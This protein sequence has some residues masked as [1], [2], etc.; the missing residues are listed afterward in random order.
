LLVKNARRMATRIH[1]PLILTL[2]MLAIL[3]ATLVVGGW[4]MRTIV[5]DS[6]RNAEAIRTARIYAASVLGAQLDEETGIRGYA[7]IRQRILI[8]PYYVGRAAFPS[9]VVRLR[10][11]LEARHLRQALIALD[12]AVYVNRRWNQHVAAPL[13]ARR[14]GGTYLELHG[15]WL[16]D[17]FRIDIARID[18]A[19]ANEEALTDQR[20]ETA[21]LS[22]GIFAAA[23]V[24]VVVLAALL[25]SVQQYQLSLR[26]ERQRAQ[27]EHQRRKA[28]ETRTALETERRIADTL[29]EAFSQRI[30]PTLPTVSFSAAYVPAT[31]DAKV[32]GDWYDVLQ[33]SEDRVLIAIGDVTGHGIEAVIAMNKARQLL[34]AGALLD[35]DPRRV[36]ERVNEVL[37]RDE[38]SPIT[39]I[40]GVINTRTCEFEYA[41]AGHPPPVLL[42]PKHRARLLEFGSLPLGVRA[43]TAYD[44]HCLRTGPGAMI[45]LYTD[46]VIEHSRDLAA[47]EAALLEAVE[48][49][50]K[51]PGAEAA[52]DIRDRIFRSRDIS[53][54][55]AILTIRFADA[56]GGVA[57]ANEN[58]EPT[59]TAPGNMGKPSET[60][61]HA[62]WRIA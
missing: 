58:R 35:S 1:A 46:G 29:Q 44:T 16:V 27:S 56:P 37:L 51:R 62:L 50:A 13:R 11:S 31:E 5:A 20:T 60:G 15:K 38:A 33:L 41:V 61:P 57:V 36:L 3:V 34:I 39:A 49:A 17:R 7:T 10:R 45:V 23:A 32:G 4:L 22:V 18:A 48:S 30:F 8:G 9:A 52:E 2:V 54:D 43:E 55:V 53:D 42:E 25:F 28:A 47:G 21:T 12:D 59:F 26:L 24:V 19:L 14:R 6:F 40:A